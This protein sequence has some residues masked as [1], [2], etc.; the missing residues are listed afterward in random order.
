[1]GIFLRRDQGMRQATIMDVAR[2]APVSVAPVSRAMNRQD[3][4]TAKT[5]ERIRAATRCIP[6]NAPRRL[7]TRRR[8]AVGALLPDRRGE[9]F[10]GRSHGIQLQRDSDRAVSHDG[11]QHGERIHRRAGPP[12]A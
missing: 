3:G 9:F 10:S 8:P 1:M 4:V 11:A 12:C 6:A 5:V 2:V 7:I